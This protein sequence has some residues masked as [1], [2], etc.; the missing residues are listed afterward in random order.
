MAL[1]SLATVLTISI[2]RAGFGVDQALSSRYTSY[3]VYFYIALYLL[4]LDLAPRRDG[5]LARLCLGAILAVMALSTVAAY[6]ESGRV[7][8]NYQ[9]SRERMAYYLTHYPLVGDGELRM[10]HYNVEK[11][12]EVAQ[13]LKVHQLN[14]FAARHA[15]EDGLGGLVRL[16]TPPLSA[17]DERT[18]KSTDRAVWIESWAVDPEWQG[19]AGGM[20]VRVNGEVY[21]ALYGIDRPDVSAYLG[22][23]DYEYSGFLAIVPRAAWKPGKNLVEFLVLSHD[24]KGYFL[25]RIFEYQW[26]Q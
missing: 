11:V 25:P 10:L 1:F 2:G 17:I 4:L 7:G 13:F 19:A 21:S 14:C 23:A 16:N 22:R 6:G 24:K 12:R 9:T 26:P 5:T 15:Q 8:M 18:F 20:L 3:T